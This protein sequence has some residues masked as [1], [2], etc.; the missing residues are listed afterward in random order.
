MSVK[1]TLRDTAASRLF[2]D[3]VLFP[4]ELLASSSDNDSRLSV[5]WPLK[6]LFGD[7]RDSSGWICN[8]GGSLLFGEGR[9]FPEPEHLKNMLKSGRYFYNAALIFGL[10]RENIGKLF[11]EE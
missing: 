10:S 5:D 2:V 11:L 3:P 8:G 7:F 6:I 1:L 4:P 9:C